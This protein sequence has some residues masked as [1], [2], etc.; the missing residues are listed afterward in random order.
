MFKIFNHNLVAVQKN[1]NN[2][3][4]NRPVYV[5]FVI[6]ELSKYHT[7]NFHYNF[8][9]QKYGDNSRLLFTDTNSLT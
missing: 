5:G 8:K 2:V 6:L 9:K 3:I 4:L 7:Y 1:K